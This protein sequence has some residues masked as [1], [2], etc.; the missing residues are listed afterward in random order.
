MGLLFH[1]F[2]PSGLVFERSLHEDRFVAH[3]DLPA[4]HHHAEREVFIHDAYV[5]A[6]I[7]RNM[8]VAL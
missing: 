6:L 2:N 5:S 4:A 3:H 7:L 8:T 1:E